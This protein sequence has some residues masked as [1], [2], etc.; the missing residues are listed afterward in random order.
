MN[1]FQFSCCGHTFTRFVRSPVTEVDCPRCRQLVKP[2]VR[3]QVKG[4]EQGRAE[5]R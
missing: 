2:L 5:K 4:D 3:L 1:W